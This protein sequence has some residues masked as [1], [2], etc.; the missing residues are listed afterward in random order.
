MYN[1]KLH[2]HSLT[3]D[4][5]TDEGGYNLATETFNEIKTVW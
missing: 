1:N 2:L 5:T 3:L 4:N